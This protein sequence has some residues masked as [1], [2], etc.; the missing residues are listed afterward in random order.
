[1]YIF[2]QSGYKYNCYFSTRTPV[3]LTIYISYNNNNNNFYCY[4]C[5]C[6][7][8]YYYM[9]TVCDYCYCCC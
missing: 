4:C 3:I 6:F 9:C 8:Y 5:C 1:M 7:Y 2:D